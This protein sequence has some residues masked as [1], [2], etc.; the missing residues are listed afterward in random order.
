M[1]S[2][3]S[4][5]FSR[6]CSVPEKSALQPLTKAMQT[7]SHRE[8]PFTYVCKSSCQDWQDWY[9][10]NMILKPFFQH[11]NAWLVVLL[12]MERLTGVFSLNIVKIIFSRIKTAIYVGLIIGTFLAFNVYFV[13]HD[14][15]TVTTPSGISSCKLDPFT[16]RFKVRQFLNGL[17]PLC[18]LIPC[19]ILTIIKVVLLV[20]S[21]RGVVAE[22]QLVLLKKKCI[23]VTIIALAITLS[24]T[25]LIIPN[26]IIVFC[27]NF[28]PSSKIIIVVTLMPFIDACLKFY[29]FVVSSTRFRIKVKSVFTTIWSSLTSRCTQNAGPSEPQNIQLDILGI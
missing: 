15:T 25:V 9:I 3:H 10:N 7:V 5:S 13:M 20:R 27:C 12:S 14:V 8:G 29:M 18:I 19:E 4:F 21:V 16:T 6:S 23:R 28:R 2:P 24:F 22:T 26:N 17:I 11:L 1:V